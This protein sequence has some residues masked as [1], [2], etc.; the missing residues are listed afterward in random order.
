MSHYF[1]TLTAFLM[2]AAI[3]ILAPLAAEAQPAE[4]VYRIGYMGPNRINPDFRQGLS[5]LG[6]V[7][8]KNLAILFRQ[9][10]GVVLYPGH[11]EEL[12]ARKVD[13]IL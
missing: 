8:G 13:L 6:Y 7:E 3:L 9:G 4:K 5:E 2:V 10:T 12:V 11:A 1:N